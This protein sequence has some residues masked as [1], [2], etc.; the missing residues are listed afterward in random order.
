MTLRAANGDVRAPDLDESGMG[1]HLET[2]IGR[3]G[4]CC[5]RP[6]FRFPNVG[7]RQSPETR[8]GRSPDRD[9]PILAAVDGGERIETSL[10]LV[11]GCPS[12]AGFVHRTRLQLCM[13]AVPPL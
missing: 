11:A 2:S 7:S 6:R 3:L 12:E 5:Q 13:R 1:A 10:R 8:I 4:A 9:G